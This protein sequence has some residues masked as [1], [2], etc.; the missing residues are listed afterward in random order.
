MSETQQ[1]RASELVEDFNLFDD[2][3]DRYRYLI[4]LGSQIPPL[5]EA[6]KSEE[7]RVHGCQSNVWLVARA[8]GSAPRI[9]F[10]ADSDSAIV[11]GLIAVLQRV[12]SG[13]PADAVLSFDIDA[14][15]DRLGLSQHLSM[16]RRN[17]L[18]GMVQR[19]KA[20]ASSA[21]SETAAVAG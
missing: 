17:G 4:D 7:N 10:V 18:A 20:L 1:E 12:Y 3:E 15:L 2:W 13:Q 16:N 21:A 8:E 14:L 19:I 11:K 6:A 9:D 5:D